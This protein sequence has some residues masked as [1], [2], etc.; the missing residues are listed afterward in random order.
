MLAKPTPS[1]NLADVC[2]YK[3]LSLPLHQHVIFE[4][5]NYK[6]MNTFGIHL[7]LTTFGESHGVAI[8]GVLDGFPANFIIDEAAIQHELDRR[9]GRT[10]NSSHLSQRAK[11]EKD[12]IEWLSGIYEG[13]TLGTP[14][15]FLVRNT[16]AHTADYDALRDVY[17]P[18]H[19]DY[20]YQQKYG[21]RDHRGGGRASARE[22]VV[23]VIA[24]ALAKQWLVQKGIT[25]VADADVK[26]IVS[27]CIQGVPVGV[28]EPIYDKLSARLAYAMLSI[29]ACK[30]FDIGTG[31]D[32]VNYTAAELNDEM[33]RDENGN[34]SFTS[35]HAGGILGGISTGQDI[36]FR[37][38]FRPAPSIPDTQKTINAQAENVEIAIQGRHDTHLALR[39]PAIVE[40]MAALTLMDLILLAR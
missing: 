40:C 20:V 36:V 26:G 21:F 33:R 35:N 32:T 15:A 23:R 4:L 22:T 6:T 28:G 5:L 12:T 37:C 31:F 17:R 39:A 9:A 38:V 19:A 24:G 27:C 30:G 10:L 14:I 8:G 29:N 25:I 7:R 13:K 18:G 34:V 2:E 16:D 11:R 1:A 3:K